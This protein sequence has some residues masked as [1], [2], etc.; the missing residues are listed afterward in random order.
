MNLMF[1]TFRREFEVFEGESTRSDVVL[2][3]QTN[4]LRQ[5]TIVQA[6]FS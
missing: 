1:H 5:S 4:L 3:A 2:T 6:S